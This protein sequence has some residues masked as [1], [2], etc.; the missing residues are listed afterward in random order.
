MTNSAVR[1]Y[2]VKAF[3]TLCWQGKLTILLSTVIASIL[4]VIIA[5]TAPNL[6]KSEV[7]LE[8]VKESENKLSS[9]A[10]EIGQLASFAGLSLGGSGENQ[11]AINLAILSSRKFISQFIDKHQL[12]V[13]LFASESWDV[14]SGK[15]LIN[16]DVFDEKT[17][18][19]LRKTK[20]PLKAK[21]SKQEAVEAF[22]NIFSVAVDQA[23]TLIHAQITFISADLANKWLTLLIKDYNQYIRAED[24]HTSQKNIEYLENKAESVNN[25]NMKLVFFSLLE[26]E[27]KKIMLA[28]VSEEYVFKVIDP[29]VAAEKRDSPKRALICV[30][31]AILGGFIGVFII[32]IR[33]F[34]RA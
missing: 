17:G 33:Q 15:L 31:G 28:Q 10:S 20:P 11:K 6:Y 22:K 4:S 8:Y 25:S 23:T 29:S 13:P 12:L 26:E 27:Q 14:V 5:I 16:P 3:F 18:K 34:N 2:G 19:W 7:A 21:P 9:S 32:L 30:A 24:L 1:V